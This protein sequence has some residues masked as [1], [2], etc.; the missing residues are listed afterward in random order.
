MTTTGSSNPLKAFVKWVL[1]GILITLTIASILLKSTALAPVISIHTN[2][3]PAAKSQLFFKH[4]EEYSERNSEISKLNNSDHSFRFTLPRFD[5]N[6]RWDPLEAAGTFYVTSA[7]INVLGYTKPIESKNL[8]PLAQIAITATGDKYTQFTVPTGATDPQINIQ[9]NGKALDKIRL[10]FSLAIAA[11]MATIILLWIKWHHRILAM[12]QSENRCTI[13]LRTFIAREHFTASEFARLVAIA[14]TLNIIP[15]VNFFLSIDDEVGAFRTDP[16]IW[17]ADGRWTAFLVEKFIFP[18]PVLP[19]LPNFFFYICLALSYMLLLRAFRLQLNWATTL[20]YAVLVAHPIWWFIGEFYSNIPSTGIG[21]LTLSTG[22]YLFSGFKPQ[23]SKNSACIYRLLACGFLLAVAI[24][25]YQSLAMFYI[26]AGLAVT[27]F[28]YRD[29]NQQHN[30][31]FAPTFKRSL[32][33]FGTVACG[34]V[35]YFAINKFAQYLYPSERSYI[36]NFLRMQ[37]LIDTPFQIIN[38]VMTEAFKLYSGSPQSYGVAFFSS[39]IILCLAIVLLVTQKTW[40]AACGMALLV[41]TMLITP[42]LLNFVAGGIYLPLR[43]MLAVS[44]IIWIATIVILERE[45]MLRIFAASLTLFLLFQMLSVNAQ[46]SASTIMATN[47][48]RFTAE[49]I[50]TR[51]A[52]VIPNFDRT[53]RVE[54]D[55]YGKL[56]FSSRYPD[57]STSTMS[58]SFFDWDNGN[59]SRMIR[60]IQ[61]VGFGNVQPVQYQ[62]RI[63]LTPE[64]AGMPIWPAEG[65]VRYKDGV[66]LIKM[67]DAVDPTH[68]LYMENDKP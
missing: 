32:F 21:V 25:A 9:L 3:F 17:I 14:V 10:V 24:G 4:N 1:S 59:A 36:D 11:F 52:K 20:G 31:V 60:Y 39:A 30:F 53:A 26:S 45:G 35:I 56:P 42:F 19:F 13:A 58:S 44:F 28:N 49:A 62:Q 34:A 46:Y 7:T 18:Q 33:L 37:E 5:N 47:H 54:V 55:I 41:A 22:I 2:Q 50:Y 57:P 38:L 16:S 63:G 66:V 27:I 40:Q 8:I 48:D 51:I 6:V 43:A 61:L 65:S 23:R 15:I 64:F 29:D 68:A 67:G 12:L